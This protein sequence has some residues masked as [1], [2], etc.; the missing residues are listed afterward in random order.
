MLFNDKIKCNFVLNPHKLF[1][2]LS[3]IWFLF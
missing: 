3:W 1:Q 2:W